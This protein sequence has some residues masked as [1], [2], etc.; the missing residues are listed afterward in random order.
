MWILWLLPR[1]GPLGIGPTLAKFY[2]AGLD[3]AIPLGLRNRSLQG[4]DEQAISIPPKTARNHT[5]G[6]STHSHKGLRKLPA[7]AREPKNTQKPAKNSKPDTI[8][9]HNDVQ[10][11]AAGIDRYLG[12][13]S[14][15]RF[16]NMRK[17]RN[18]RILY[19]P[20]KIPANIVIALPVVKGRRAKRMASTD[21]QIPITAD[22]AQSIP[23]AVWSC[24]CQPPTVNQSL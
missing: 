23:S 15:N 10:L 13:P 21:P 11:R 24:R 22:S 19:R 16:K 17:S 14:R 8:A 12:I 6:H 5:T 3:D 1:V 7:T 20:S 4:I 2:V 18:E 9:G